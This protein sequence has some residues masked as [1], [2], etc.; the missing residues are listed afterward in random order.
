MLKTLSAAELAQKLERKVGRL[1]LDFGRESQRHPH[2]VLFGERETSWSNT[3]NGAG[4][5]VENQRAAND[6]G[7][8]A[9]AGAP[10]SVTQHGDKIL[11]GFLVRGCE[12][13]SLLGR[14]AEFFEEAI[15]N[16]G[17]AQLCWITLSRQGFFRIRVN[18]GCF[19]RGSL[20]T[21]LLRC[22]PGIAEVECRKHGGS[23]GNGQKARRILEGKRAKKRGVHDAEDGG[24][25]ANA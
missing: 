21:N 1:L 23:G 6:R 10:E 14:R 12:Q 8:S 15:R 9:K 13:A 24:V 20:R 18:N 22:R 16:V 5:L 19:E 4:L 25:G 3:D 11:S 7:I 2:V 17:D